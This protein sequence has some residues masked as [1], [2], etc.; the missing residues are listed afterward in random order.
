[1]IVVS[2]D[3]SRRHAAFDRIVARRCHWKGSEVGCTEG[4]AVGE[5]SSG[6]EEGGS[7]EG[8]SATAHTADGVQHIP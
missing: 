3:Q 2:H 6:S 4:D 1:M 5:E 8:T 7:E